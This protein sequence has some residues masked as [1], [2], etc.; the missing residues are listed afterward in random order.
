MGRKVDVR[1]TELSIDSADECPRGLARAQNL[2]ATCASQGEAGS[3]TEHMVSAPVT[4][5][6]SA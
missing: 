2:K 4:A 3:R 5:S 1:R 6:K